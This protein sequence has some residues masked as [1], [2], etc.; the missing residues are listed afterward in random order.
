M[1]G[2]IVGRILNSQ[3]KYW[4]HSVILKNK[5]HKVYN[6]YGWLL[7]KYSEWEKTMNDIFKIYKGKKVKLEFSIYVIKISLKAKE[8]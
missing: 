4:K 7:I 2:H 8:K 1:P 6:Y 5:L 3:R